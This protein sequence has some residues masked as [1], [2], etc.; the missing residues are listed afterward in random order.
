MPSNAAITVEELCAQPL[1]MFSHSARAF[2]QLRSEPGAPWDKYGDIILKDPG[3]TLGTLNALHGNAAKPLKSEISS[4]AQAAMLLGMDRVQGLPG[5]VPQV[6]QMLRGAARAGYCK[7]VTR[8]FHA[9]YQAWDWA[10]I[11]RD[12]APD[13]ILLSALM[14][15]AAELALWVVAPDRIQ[16]LRHLII[17]D[18]MAVDEAQYIALGDSLEHFSRRLAEAWHLPPLVHEALRPEYTREPRSQGIVLA[19]QL[20]RATEWGWHSQETQTALEMI[21]DYLNASVAETTAHIHQASV[22]AAREASFYGGRPAAALLPLQ[23]GGEELVIEE[24][25]PTPKAPARPTQPRI[26]ET[27][28][29]EVA[30]A[31]QPQ[32]EDVVQQGSTQVCL[33]P[34][35]TLLAEIVQDIEANLGKLGINEL[36]RKVV[37]GMHDGAGLNRALFAMLNSDRTHLQARFMIGS[38]NDP[39]FNR[40]QISLDKPHLFTRLMEKPQSLRIHD[41]NRA[42]FWPLVPE[43]IKTLIKTNAFC[44]QSVHLKG[45]PV[46]LFYADRHNPEC[47]LDEHTYEHFRQLCRL[48]VQGLAM[49]A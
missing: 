33:S 41:G 22:R 44:A 10:H 46:G 7:V 16:Q 48:A 35:P 23:P 31:T 6:E 3:L 24:E 12:H 42:K 14:H 25:F 21:A 4:M 18:K 27:V 29:A 32:P 45:K 26:T 43:E 40:F 1:P 9:A 2:H 11:R 28:S 17:K 5:S 15:D 47:S 34:Q 13:E 37:H 30:E 20:A 38:D 39:A 36:M 19:V 8:C 49:R